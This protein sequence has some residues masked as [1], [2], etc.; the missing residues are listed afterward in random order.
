M[1]LLDKLNI[2]ER[3][4]DLCIYKSSTE[5]YPELLSTSTMWTNMP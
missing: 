1:I 4:A 3:K 2:R 5:D